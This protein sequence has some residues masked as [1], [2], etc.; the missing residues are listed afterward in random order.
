MHESASLLQL[1]G[2][3]GFGAVVGWFLYYVNRY[4]SGDL[5]LGDVVTVVSALGGGAILSLFPAESDLFA[6][7]GLG[8]FAGFFGYLL[9]LVVLVARSPNFDADWFLDGRR[10]TPAGFV[11]VPPEATQ[12]ARAMDREEGVISG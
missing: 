2:A 6:A 11:E 5:R 4:R 3:G 10:R 9:V 8:L 7:Y 12:T 1:L